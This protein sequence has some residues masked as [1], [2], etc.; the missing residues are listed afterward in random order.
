MRIFTTAIVALVAG[1]LVGT[2]FSFN[3]LW[4]PYKDEM[5]DSAVTAGQKLAID[6]EIRNVFEMILAAEKLSDKE[7]AVVVPFL[8]Q[9]VDQLG[10][11]NDFKS[12]L[13]QRQLAQIDEAKQLN[14]FFIESM[15]DPCQSKQKKESAA[16]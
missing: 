15:G 7:R 9:V 1:F 14:F 12:N 4:E 10:T 16:T 2:Y 6:V 8:C 13:N 11:S 5:S 3:Y